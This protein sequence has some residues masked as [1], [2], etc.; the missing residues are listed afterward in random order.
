MTQPQEEQMVSVLQFRV[1]I[2]SYITEVLTG[3]RVCQIPLSRIAPRFGVT[4]KNKKKALAQ[5]LANYEAT[6]GEPYQ[7]NRLERIFG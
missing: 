2:N 3:M 4:T 5:L 6:M 1:L 7:D